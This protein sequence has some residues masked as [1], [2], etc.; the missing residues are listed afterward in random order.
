MLQ[1]SGSTKDIS[2]TARTANSNSKTVVH[3]TILTYYVSLMPLKWNQSSHVP[4]TSNVNTS[5]SAR[6]IRLRVLLLSAFSTQQHTFLYMNDASVRRKQRVTYKD[7]NIFTVNVT[8]CNNLVCLMIQSVCNSFTSKIT[9]FWNITLCSLVD[10]Y[11]TT[12][13]WH[14]TPE[15]CSFHTYGRENLKPHF[16]VDLNLPII[17]FNTWLIQGPKLECISF[18]VKSL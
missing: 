15:E 16:H 4:H 6:R 12:C 2:S 3:E 10:R 14:N 7:S 5:G 18:F 17:D 1:H 11:K 9:V 8:F 13:I